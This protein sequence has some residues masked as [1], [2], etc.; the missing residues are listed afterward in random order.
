MCSKVREALGERVT[1]AGP[2]EEEWEEASALGT[3]S[4]EMRSAGR[5]RARPLGSPV[6]REALLCSTLQGCKVKGSNETLQVGG[7]EDRTRALACG[8]LTRPLPSV[9]RTSLQCP[10]GTSN[11]NHP[12][13]PPTHPPTQSRKMAL[14]CAVAVLLPFILPSPASL[15]SPSPS[16]FCLPWRSPLHSH[17]LQED[18]LD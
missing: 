11:I 17:L 6:R 15:P 4:S 9:L 3:L 8:Y 14:P 16:K 10:P 18:F 12:L 13:P 7:G 1:D 5:A 2:R